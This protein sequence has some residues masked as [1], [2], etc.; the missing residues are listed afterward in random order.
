MFASA[1]LSAKA[2][3]KTIQLHCFNA[4]KSL[5]NQVGQKNKKRQKTRF[6]FVLIN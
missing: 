5:I 2:K 3:K 1:D 4:D 6:S